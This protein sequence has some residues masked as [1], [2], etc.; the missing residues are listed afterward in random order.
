MASAEDVTWDPAE[1]LVVFVRN[2]MYPNFREVHETEMNKRV[3]VGDTDFFFEITEFYPHFAIIDSTKEVVSFSSEPE[4]VAFKFVVFE[5]D[6]IVDT[7]WSFYNIQIPHY[8]ANSYLVFDVLKFE[9]RGEVF[10]KDEE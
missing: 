1:K 6:S 2:R 10:Q 5:N 7:S 8:A 9:Y 4:N 3:Q